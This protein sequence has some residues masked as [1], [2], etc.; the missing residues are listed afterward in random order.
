[1]SSSRASPTS[2]TTY[3]RGERPPPPPD[4]PLGTGWTEERAWMRPIG[5]PYEE[6]PATIPRAAADP[7]PS[8]YPPN[9]L[10]LDTDEGE[11]TQGFSIDG[12]FTST[13]LS[14]ISLFPDKLP[15]SSSRFP[16]R[17]APYYS[18]LPGYSPTPERGSIVNQPTSLYGR[19][20]S[21]RGAG[22]V[23][24][25]SLGLPYREEYEL[26]MQSQRVTGLSDVP[27]IPSGI[28]LGPDR[29]RDFPSW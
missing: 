28:Q 3:F 27:Y 7:S 6:S 13:P 23:W 15:I 12:G 24:Q 11:T 20:I 9:Y 26:P 2:Y 8:F 1:M 17:D 4:F 10:G 18:P 22:T 25:T 14:P 16:S 19:V 29:E 5:S 21:P